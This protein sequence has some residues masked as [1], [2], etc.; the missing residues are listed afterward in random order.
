[1]GTF[2]HFAANT[3]RFDGERRPKIRTLSLVV[4]AVAVALLAAW[5]AG[6]LGQAR[7]FAHL[8]ERA[9]PWWLLLAV[10]FQIATY[11][12]AGAIWQR[13][14]QSSG[15]RLPLASVGKLSLIKLS[16]DQLMPSGG[17]AGN[18]VVTR[19]L[20]RLG[21]PAAFAFEAL[22]VDILAYY[23]AFAFSVA[24]A[25]L[26]LWLHHGVTAPVLAAVG[27]FSLV[28]V[29]VPGIILWLLRHR[30][31][32]PP[33]WLRKRR[34][35]SQV[36]E[37]VARVS[38][39]R[40]H[41]PGLLLQAGLLNLSVFLLDAG[42][43]WAVFRALGTHVHIL[44]SFV[45]LIMAT[46]A[47]TV[48]LLPGGLGT[49]EGGCFATLTLLGVKA[50]AALTATLL[51]RGLALWL[52][53]APGLIVA[54]RE[55]A[56]DGAQLQP[57]RPSQ[58]DGRHVAPTGHAPERFPFWSMAVAEVLSAVGS[59]PEGLATDEIA[60]RRSAPG[61]GRIVKR[62]APSSLRLLLRQFLSPLVLMLIGAATV[63]AF[64]HD[65]TDAL[66]IL[67]IV[68]AS[69]LLSFWHEH[70]AADTMTR[71]LAAVEV[72]VTAL[73]DGGT[74]ELPIEAIVPG[75]VLLL[76]AGSIVPADARVLDA[77]DCFVDESVLT[78]ETFPVEKRSDPAEP[79]AA[80]G[81]RTSA[82]FMGTHVVSG[83]AHVVAVQTGSMTQ[84]GALSGRLA[85]RAPE[86]DF[87]RGVQRFGHMLLEVTI[88]LVL[89][90]FALNVVL[91]KP[92]LD[93]FMFSVALAVGLT[94]QLL[95]AII[96]VNLAHG[97]KRLSQVKVIVKRLT[98]IENFG[99]MNV[100]CS[101]KTG[102][103]TEGTIRV[104]GGFT[105]LGR[106]SESI[107]YLAWLNA[108]FESGFR[109]PIDDAIRN[110]SRFSASEVEKLDELPYDFVRK[111]LSVAVADPTLGVVIVTKGALE[112]VLAACTQARDESGGVTALAPLLP[113]I[114]EQ[115]RALSEQ[116][117]RVLGIAT[118]PYERRK[119]ALG[120]D[121]ESGMIFEG[122]LALEDPLKPEIAPTVGDLAALGIALKMITG[123]NARVARAI[124]ERVGLS[125]PNLVTGR[126][127]HEVS[128]TALA[129]LAAR[130]DVFA[131]IEPNQKERIILALRRAGFVVGY[132]GDGINDAPALHS[133][134]V[135]ISVNSAVDVA[136]QAA[137]FVL[138]EHGLGVLIDGV[139]EGRRTF[140]NTMKYVFMAT[141]ANFGNML[142]MALASLFLPFLPLL[143]SQVLLVNLLTDLP[144]MTI[145]TDRV[146][147]DTIDKPQRW[148][149]A[150]VRRFMLVFGP[151]SSLFDLLTFVALVGMAHASAQVFRT[152]WFV[153]SVVSACLI[154]LVVRSK[155]SLR[156]SPPSRALLTA[157]L[158]V[159]ATAV[160]LPLTPVATRLGFVIPPT[161][162]MI[163]VAIIT[164]VYVIGAVVVK[165]VFYAKTN[166]RHRN[167]LSRACRHSAFPRS[168]ADRE[169]MT[170]EKRAPTQ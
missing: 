128:D 2:T 149:L 120:T 72:K 69:G 46:L 127:L 79:D 138:L 42:T 123:D 142:S 140:A 56:R 166:S 77:R 28:L 116:G 64:L 94:P 62:K 107:A 145:A 122:L 59:R 58:D 156:A 51:L 129:T 148:D 8:V 57:G 112:Q 139:K 44:T 81:A 161:R 63:S 151:L 75:D 91:H 41:N 10:G 43:L 24:L 106:S 96:S 30:N 39:K 4:G 92:A 23:G 20:Q 110:F 53:L 73:R 136:K 159:V 154:V 167:D 70:G 125:S 66:V 98:A 162:V 131:E 102:T 80:P 65:V 170:K 3:G 36:I 165:H 132:I 7:E 26:V 157:S 97:A 68:F 95:P 147:A 76:S 78:G 158:A 130:T 45:A 104:R 105:P 27:A 32:A 35:V 119:Q 133:A 86:T 85:A 82:V 150:F 5:A 18:L 100:L 52:P 47:G 169:S 163:A 118:K 11:T 34:I 55:L 50:E 12:A 83:T 48:S 135:G 160:V 103:L 22:L 121:D 38:P 117:L 88:I 61:A 143:P 155:H 13:V 21:L 152:G 71:L 108:A 93:S 153:E 33:R 19:A 9:E 111:R 89:T 87:E 126:D 99:S 6:H 74:V 164:V 54:R 67:S 1:M 109:N 137:D 17:M 146:D 16:V 113:R 29:C 31:F 14:A 115:F 144:E 90:I 49:F 141:S 40:V 124:A 168:T 101:D 114:D 25:V 60:A 15:Y 84:F 37:A 134:D